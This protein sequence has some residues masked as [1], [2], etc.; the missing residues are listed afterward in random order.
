MLD[1][2]ETYELAREIGIQTPSIRVVR[3]AA[4]L[5]GGLEEI[6]FPCGL[7]PRHSH[8]FAKHF[9][10]TKLIVAND[11]F[12]LEGALRRTDALGLEMILTEIIP[13]PETE[14]LSCC[15]YMDE[16]GEPLTHFTFS[17]IRQYPVQYGQGCYVVSDWNEEVIAEALRFLRGIGLCGLFHVE[18]KRDPRDGG[19]KL[20]ECN[21]RFTI[22]AMLAPADLP[23]LTYNRILGRPLPAPRPYRSGVHLWAPY[24]DA[25]AFPTYRRRGQLTWFSWLRSLLRR[26][27]FQGFRWDDPMPSLYSQLSLAGRW[28]GRRL[29]GS[30]S[31]LEATPLSSLEEEQTQE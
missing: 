24:M 13:G 14:L 18:F 8:H 10:T 15:G 30:R 6:G 27:R 25:R 26:K 17:K 1:K 4:D 19:L 11:R 28:L 31:A 3:S 9:R 5:D 29:R 16:H 21:H 2:V 7:K 12:E 20:M 23:L 22:E